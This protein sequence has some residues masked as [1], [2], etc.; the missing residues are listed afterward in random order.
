M[1]GGADPLRALLDAYRPA[2][3]AEA[4]DVAA[5]RAAMDGDVWSRS[6]PLHVT[7]SALVLHLESWRV[8]LRWHT[9]L[10]R[11][12][13]VGG[14][15]D[16][17]E[18]DPCLVARREAEEE[19]GLDDLVPVGAPGPMQ[20]AVVGVPAGRDGPAHR[21]ADIRYL[22]ATARPEHAAAEDPGSP[23]RWVPLAEAQR[24]VEERNLQV[25]LDRAGAV[26][27]AHHG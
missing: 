8:L 16:P 24:E 20:I 17:G 14:H 11:W 5:L 18:R 2:S 1:T 4:A 26:L 12:L 6:A 9:R 22:L 19:S 3:H 21:H 23:L 27:R 7:G 10:G 13:Q 15:A 25:L